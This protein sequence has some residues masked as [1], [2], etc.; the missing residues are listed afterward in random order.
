MSMTNEFRNRLIASIEHNFTTEQL[1]MID[2][3]VAKAFRGY[4]LEP[5]ETLPVLYMDCR[6]IEIDEFLARKRL[7]GCSKGTLM[8]YEYAMNDFSFWLRKDIKTVLDIDVLAYL[9][10]TYNKGMVSLRT[11]DGRR[12]ILSSFFTFMHDTG[13]MSYNPMKTIDRI[14]F[15]EKVREPLDDMELEKVRNAC[16]TI[17]EKAIFETL[18]STGGRVSEVVSMN[19]TDIDFDKRSVLITGKGNYERYVYF[20]PKAIIAIENYLK[21]RSDDNIALFVG[22][23]KPYKRL[24]KAS[25]ESIVR[26]IGKRS[27]V[28]RNVFPHLLR[29]TFATDML[30]HGAKINEVSKLLGHHKLETTQIY[31]KVSNNNLHNSHKMYIS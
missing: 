8:Q 31:A 26:E 17:R 11:L 24:S 14:K 30:S 9:D 10:W 29:H 18:Y 20:T 27:G 21:T 16:S 2:M 3:A 15:K 1:S 5:E 25:I 4:K 13:K 28:G 7:K 22:S 12:L 19:Y 6:P 23:R